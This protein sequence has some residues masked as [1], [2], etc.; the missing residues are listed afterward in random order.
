[1]PGASYLARPTITAEGDL[2]LW[3]HLG[4]MSREDY[5]KGP[6]QRRGGVR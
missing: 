2:I 4:M 6:R 5:R 3:E 1:M